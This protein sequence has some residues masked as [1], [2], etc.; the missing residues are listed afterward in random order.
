[1]CSNP[2][3]SEPSKK[4]SLLTYEVKSNHPLLDNQYSSPSNRRSS[5]FRNGEVSFSS[6]ALASNAQPLLLKKYTESLSPNYK[7]IDQENSMKLGG[8]LKE[9]LNNKH[10]I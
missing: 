7:N 10:G 6:L 2:I 4:M 1:M 3:D 9:W 5:H 8:L